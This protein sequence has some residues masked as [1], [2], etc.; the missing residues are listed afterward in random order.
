MRVVRPVEVGALGLNGRS[1]AAAASLVVVVGVGAYLLT[2]NT[3]GDVTAVG[4]PEP[5]EAVVTTVT[6]A[7]STTTSVSVHDDV[8]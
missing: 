5:S 2:Q 1:L 6:T 4:G 3:T 8:G 7:P